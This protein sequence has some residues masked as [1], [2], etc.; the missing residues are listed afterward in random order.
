MHETVT[1]VRRRVRD[2]RARDVISDSV[3]SR[4]QGAGLS[5]A[6]SEPLAAQFELLYREAHAWLRLADAVKAGG[7]GTGERMNELLYLSRRIRMILD[8]AIPFLERAEDT[9]SEKDEITHR[10]SAYERDVVPF[11]RLE[12]TQGFRSFLSERPEFGLELASTGAQLEADLL[13]I[14]YLETVLEDTSPK[15]SD[16]YAMV[17]ELLLDARRHL[18]P[19][20]EDGSA[21]MKALGKAAQAR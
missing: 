6:L 17:M 4:L 21:F 19:G 12:S 8:D 1:R 15:P 18:G 14:V 2:E 7:E 20:F 13:K 16:L 9:L 5:R 3:S 10:E 11:S